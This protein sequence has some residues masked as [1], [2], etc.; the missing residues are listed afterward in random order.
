MQTKA[1]IVKHVVYTIV[2]CGYSDRWLRS[3]AHYTVRYDGVTLR[4]TDFAG[5]VQFL[6]KL[7]GADFAQARDEVNSCDVHR[8]MSGRAWQGSLPAWVSLRLSLEQVAAVAK[9]L[10]LRE[11]HTGKWRAEAIAEAKEY[12][13]EHPVSDQ[14]HQIV[15]WQLYECDRKNVE[16]WGFPNGQEGRGKS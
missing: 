8:I 5:V 10:M 15:L 2:T 6:R 14:L 7:A 12:L 13:R 3:E 1:H 9:L 11:E 16:A 4:L